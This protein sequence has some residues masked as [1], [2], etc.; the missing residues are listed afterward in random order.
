M[1]RLDSF[2]PMMRAAASTT[3]DCSRET[4]EVRDGD[5][6]MQTPVVE[7]T[8]HMGVYEVAPDQE[9]Q[10]DCPVIDFHDRRQHFTANA[11]SIVDIE[12]I[13]DV[14]IDSSPDLTASDRRRR[15]LDMENIDPGSATKRRKQNLIQDMS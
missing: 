6:V 11:D 3:G 7:M 15:P 4:L 1:A 8:L 12:M 13:S 5:D 14:E 9:G 10:L 2:M